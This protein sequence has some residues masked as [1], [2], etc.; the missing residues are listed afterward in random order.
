MFPDL[1]PAKVA[2]PHPVLIDAVPYLPA[3]LYS[4][5][6]SVRPPKVTDTGPPGEPDLPLYLAFRNLTL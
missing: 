4:G 1:S 3:S 6:T 2:V 5:L